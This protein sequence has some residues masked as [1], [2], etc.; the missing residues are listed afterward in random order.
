MSNGS[1][2]SVL[3]SFRKMAAKYGGQ[4]EMKRMDQPEYIRVWYFAIF[5]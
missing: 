5:F 4:N 1:G 3:R 2:F